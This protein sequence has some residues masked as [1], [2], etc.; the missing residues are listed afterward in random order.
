MF[1][2]HAAAAFSQLLLKISEL[3]Y[4]GDLHFDFL[5]DF[6]CFPECLPAKQFNSADSKRPPLHKNC[7]KNNSLASLDATPFR[8][9]LRLLP[10]YQK[11]NLDAISD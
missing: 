6:R 5:F 8:L 3:Y 7:A 11:F 1:A 4:K 9:M 10:Q 2:A